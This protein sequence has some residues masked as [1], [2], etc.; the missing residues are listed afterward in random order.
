[1][2]FAK[3]LSVRAWS[4]LRNVMAMCVCVCVVCIYVFGVYQPQ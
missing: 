3:Y 4:P 1:M 2:F